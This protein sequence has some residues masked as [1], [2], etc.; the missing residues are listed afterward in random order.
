M[1]IKQKLLYLFLGIIIL[2]AGI[3]LRTYRLNWDQNHHLHPDERFLTMVLLDID[4]PKSFGEY[5]DTGRS[6]LNP[7]NRGH[8]FFVYGTLPLFLVKKLSLIFNQ[9]D[10]NAIT[11]L[12]RKTA[13]A[14]EAGTLLLL[15]FLAAKKERLAFLWPPFLYAFSVLAIQQSHFFTTDV[16][17]TFFITLAF[18]FCRQF[19]HKDHWGWLAGT[20]VSLGAAAACKISAL[21][22]LPPLAIVF[23]IWLWQSKPWSI[24]TKIPLF[25]LLFLSTWRLL[26]PYAFNG[27]LQPNPQFLANLKELQN[28]SRAP[29]SFPPAV[30]W[31]NTTPIIFPLKNLLFWGWGLPLGLLIL[32]ALIWWPLK[33]VAQSSKQNKT[34]LWLAWGIIVFWL[35]FQGSQ[36]SKLMRYFLPIFPLAAFLTADWLNSWHRPRLKVILALSLMIWP[37][38]FMNIY[39]QPHPRISASRWI[40]QNVPSGSRLSCEYWDDCLP[41]DQPPDKNFKTTMIKPWGKD[42]PAKMATLNAQLEEIDYFI[43]SSPRIWRVV[44]NHPALYPKTGQFYQQLLEENLGF[45]KVAEFTNRPCFPPT[46]KHLFCLPDQKAEE[47]FTVHDH[48]Q[49]IILKKVNN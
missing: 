23:I 20:A 31:V 34:S 41:L 16:F 30:Q 3:F 9:V 4:W 19:W 46:A 49:V 36:I 5:L 13:V 24:L 17:L 2:A 6:P 8:D 44:T 28:L 25:I 22:F 18:L 27:L 29:E 45:T 21:I 26:Q 39:R 48:P 32:T 40:N 7:Y 1:A 15:V 33:S 10:Y 38:S 14:F 35:I 12:G 37:I 42:T 11:L 43:L 47:A